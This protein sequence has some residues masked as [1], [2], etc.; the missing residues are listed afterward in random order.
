MEP[1]PVGIHGP[2]TDPQADGDFLRGAAVEQ[3][4]ENLVLADGKDRPVVGDPVES[5]HPGKNGI[6]DDFAA[7]L[8]DF[9]RKVEEFDVTDPYVPTGITYDLDMFEPQTPGNNSAAPCRSPSRPSPA[10]WWPW[11]LVRSC[12]GTRSEKRSLRTSAARAEHGPEQ[13]RP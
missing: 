7:F 11:R 13:D 9:D 3:K 2:G 12:P 10:C 8:G 5:E 6:G 1:L 4:G